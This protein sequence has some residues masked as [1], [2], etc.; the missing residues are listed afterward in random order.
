MNFDGTELIPTQG[1]WCTCQLELNCVHMWCTVVLYALLVIHAINI[2]RPSPFFFFLF[3]G[4]HIWMLKNGGRPGLIHH[5]S[6][7]K[8]DVG[9]EGQIFQTK[10]KTSFLLVKMNSFDHAC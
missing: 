8:M 2:V 10:P 9:G 6:G 3:F 7:R 5:V 1:C 4:L